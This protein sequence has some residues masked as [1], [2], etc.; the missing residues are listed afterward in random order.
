MLSPSARSLRSR[1][2]AYK[3]HSTH[4]PRETTANA[5]AAF[6]A[7]FEDEV[8]PNRTLPDGERLRRADMARKSSFAA[9]AYRSSVARAKRGATP[10]RAT[11]QELGHDSDLIPARAA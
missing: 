4:D 2:G 11:P 10:D 6:L 3:L 1:I 8:D 5:R 7:R 9:L